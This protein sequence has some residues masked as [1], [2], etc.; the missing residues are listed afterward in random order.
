MIPECPLEWFEAVNR[1]LCDNF[2]EKVDLAFLHAETEDNEE[3]VL[4]A[5]AKFYLNGFAPKIGIT[6]LDRSIIDK[7]CEK[8]EKANPELAK[9]VRDNL[10]SDEKGAITGYLGFK[11]W[12]K[13]LINLGVKKED[14]LLI[15][16]DYKFYPCTDAEAQGLVDFCKEE[17]IKNVSVTSPPFHQVRSYISG[18]SALIQKDATDIKFYSRPGEP[19]NWNQEAVHS[20]GIAKGI[21]RVLLK[22]ELERILK[23]HEAGNP[24][25]VSLGQ[26]IDYLNKR[27]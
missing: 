25:L 23:Y 8:Y 3:S 12:E 24:P 11:H 22:G 16:F 14:I 21:R 9:R 6:W 26:V 10:K 15:E 7:V 27:D 4:R 19:I 18:I 13:A 5:G 20:Q 17:R 1:I 2:P